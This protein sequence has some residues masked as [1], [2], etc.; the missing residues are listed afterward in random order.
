VSA[1]PVS[2]WRTPRSRSL[3]LVGTLAALGGAVALAA[4]VYTDA[5]WF[6][7][8][9]QEDV[10]WESLTWKVLARGVPSFGTACFLL[11]NFVAV[12]RAMAAH[13]PRRP[14]RVLA[15]PAAAVAAGVI[16][17]QWGAEGLWRL[18]ALWSGRSDFG[19]DDPLFGRDVGFFVFSLPLYEWVSRW[20]L[21]MLV[22]GAVATVA[23]YVAAGGLRIARPRVLVPGARAHLLVLGALAL[24]VVAWRYRLDQY[25]LALP[26]DGASGAGYTEAHVRLPALR[27]L[28][29]VSLAGAALLLYAAVRRVRRRPLAILVAIAALALASPGVVSRLVERVEVAPQA[30][31]RERP[32]VDHSIAATRRAFALDRVRV[33][34]VSGSGR[35]SRADINAHRSTLENV[36]L[37]DRRV[38]RP[39]MDDL[40]SIGRYYSFPSVTVDRYPA[41]SSSQ[42]VT[43][44]AR[45]LDLRALGDDA[46]GW[47]NERFAY[48]HG[49]GVVAV[50]APQADR[51]GQPP[52]AERDFGSRPDVVGLREP[53]IYYSERTGP[54]PEYVIVR[55]RRAEVDRPLPGSSAPD[56][57]Y[58]GS[59]GIALASVLRR[60]AFAIRF[61]DP[62]LLLTETVTDRS[63]IV[64]HRDVRDRLRTLAPFL[65]WDVHAQTVVIGGRVQFVFHGYTTSED[66]PYSAPV[67]IG[68]SNV[69]YMRAAAVAVVDGF[70]GRIA[71]YA[72]DAHDP[73]LRAW[74]SAFPGLFQP[75]ERMP[76]ELRAHLRYPRR[77]FIAQAQQYTTYHA[78][79]PTAFWN[80][81]DAW[82]V[83]QQIAGPLEDAG[84]IQFP[85]PTPQV[86]DDRWATP[87]RYLLARLPGDA[88]ERFLL[89]LP[90]SPRGRQNLVGYLAGSMAP[91]GAPELTLLSLPRDRLELGPAQATR[92]I[93]ASAEVSQ[94]L[95]I[96]NRESRD[97]GK[98]AVSRTVLGAPRLVPVGDALV[99]VQPIYLTAGG[100]GVPR[101]QLVTVLANGH[102]GYGRDLETALRRAIR[103][104]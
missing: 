18:L 45:Q 101:L 3:L 78:D 21:G 5:L 66:Y 53:R 6:R 87:S 2:L 63:R 58:G 65:R 62:K 75:S 90:F 19:V 81:A 76:A 59:G 50:A 31:T 11:A 30:L 13:A 92:R 60:T 71:L 64:L 33:R 77:L 27:I 72:D 43:L 39:A 28:H 32:Y 68:R 69:N 95:Q 103:P 26:H 4:Q 41:G 88:T 55:S 70:D 56:Y 84:E 82:Q 80:G 25:A 49:Y 74:S 14:A 99:H 22:M 100:G 89:A 40:Q 46:R 44:A 8:V 79:E 1:R 29:W 86:D 98:A 20:L 97:L 9:G 10:F 16:T 67:R 73:I 54:G 23:A 48:T 34:D 94:R 38:L 47:A 83:P 42:V 104:R 15:Y 7:E 37:W 91:D 102:V 51:I 35:L 52:F 85:D 12:E 93:L 24:V 17:G 61:G 36:P 57:H 96:V